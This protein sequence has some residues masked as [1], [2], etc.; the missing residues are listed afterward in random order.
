MH[1]WTQAEFLRLILAIRDR[2]EAGFDIEAAARVGIEFLVVLRKAGTPP[3]P[4]QRVATPGVSAAAPPRI[5]EE[6]RTVSLRAI[7]AARERLAQRRSR[8]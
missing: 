1:V 8:P 3:A 6:A 2:A 5:R 7:S 4:N